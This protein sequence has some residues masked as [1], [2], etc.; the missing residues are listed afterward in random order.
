VLDRASST[1]QI[2]NLQ[3]EITKK[4]APPCATTDAVFY[5]GTG[6]LLCR[7]EDKVRNCQWLGFLLRLSMSS[8]P[9]LSCT[10]FSTSVLSCAFTWSLALPNPDSAA[11]AASA[12]H[13]QMTLFDV[14]QRTVLAELSTPYVKYVIWNN[15]MTQVALLS[16]HA[17]IIADKKLQNAQTV[18]ETIRVKVGQE[19]LVHTRHVYDVWHLDGR[20]C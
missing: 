9:P 8:L 19:H 20:M 16:K 1:I 10:N 5:A 17:I 7:S 2:R 4:C 15:D 13:A 12:L 3:N 11:P 14:Q 6:M 18:H